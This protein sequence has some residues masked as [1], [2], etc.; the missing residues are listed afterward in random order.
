[1]SALLTAEQEAFQLTDSPYRTKLQQL[2]DLL[3]SAIQVLKTIPSSKTSTN[4]QDRDSM[5]QLQ[6][7]IE[8]FNKLGIQEQP[9]I[10]DA[11]HLARACHLHVLIFYNLV[12][13]RVPHR[14]RSNQE[15][16]D[17]LFSAF[18][19]I[20]DQT[21]DE[22]PYLRLWVLLTGA[23]ASHDLKKKSFFKAQLVRGIYQMGPG[24]FRRVKGMSYIGC[25]PRLC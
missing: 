21:W 4:R 24:E 12:V 23:V 11:H 9:G 18:R 2:P 8:R 14:H 22:I 25:G 7:N 15:Y 16:A 5:E 1:M 13:H 3:D 6:Q 17:A 10:P 19:C 20:R